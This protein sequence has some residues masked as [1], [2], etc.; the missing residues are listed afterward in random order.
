[1]DFYYKEERIH[2]LPEKAAYLPQYGMLLI[3]DVHLGKAS[4]F[5][6][7][8]IIIPVPEIS[9]DL[10]S[11]KR[12][13]QNLNPTT[14]VFMG[15]LF[16]SKLNS[17]WLVLK[18]FLAEHNDKHFILTKGN[19]DI[20]PSN[21]WKETT[22]EVVDELRVGNHLLC[23]HEPITENPKD[24][25]NIAGHIHPGFLIKT[26]GKQSY[27]LPCF[28][29]NRNLLILPAFGQLT[30]LQIMK[31]DPRARVFPVLPTEVIEWP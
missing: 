24:V 18:E 19:H 11:I 4:H 22:I 29:H 30:G 15:D 28:Y 21:I 7:E 10:C 3:A 26:R 8:G 23:T 25:L 6:K 5:R 9:P 17:E 1:M 27:R 31:K 16:H 14:I 12:M 13:I 2:L 20:L